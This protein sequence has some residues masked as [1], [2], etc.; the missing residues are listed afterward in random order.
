MEGEVRASGPPLAG[1]DAPGASA[2]A[3]AGPDPHGR[4]SCREV[5]KR[6]PRHR[7]R[8]P[9]SVRRSRS[10]R[11]RGW[12]SGSSS[13]APGEAAGLDARLDLHRR[14]SPL[15][16]DCFRRSRRAF[17]D[18]PGQAAGADGGLDLHRSIGG[19]GSLPPESGGRAPSDAPHDAA[20]ADVRLDGHQT[21]QA[22][23][24]ARTVVLIFIRSV[25]VLV[26]GL[27]PAEPPGPRRTGALRCSG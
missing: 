6:G 2:G 23:P 17:S 20:G 10:C 9:W 19:G 11:R 4:V 7:V 8:G 14:V 3:N 21:I 13:D 1:S 25:P 18:A 5:E 16:V 22:L 15:W 24:P 26:G 12:W 27:V